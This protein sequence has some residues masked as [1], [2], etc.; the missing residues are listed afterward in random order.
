DREIC[1]VEHA[2]VVDRTIQWIFNH[3]SLQGRRPSDPAGQ[4]LQLVVSAAY[5]LAKLDKAAI[6]ELALTDLAALWPAVKDAT[7]LRSWVVTEHGATFSVRPGI[8]ELR[9][10]ARTPIEGLFLAGDWTNTGWPAT[11]EG[12]VRSGYRAAEEVTIDL[13]LPRRL[14]QPELQQGWLARLL[15]G[16]STS[17]TGPSFVP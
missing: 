2:V 14:V 5:E 10:K 4:Y 6:L 15:L 7:V 3:T 17:A 16:R 9:P 12:A 8:D 1:P 11:M 13:G